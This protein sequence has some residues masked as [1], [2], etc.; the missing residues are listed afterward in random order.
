[1]SG[2]DL[3]GGSSGDYL[4][5]LEQM[6][7]LKKAFEKGNKEVSDKIDDQSIELHQLK[8]SITGDDLGN[9]GIAQR[10]SDTE[11]SA[12]KNRAEIAAMKNDLKWWGILVS[13]ISGI[14]AL[15]ITNWNKIFS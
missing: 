14:L 8:I 12:V 11:H 9:K 10:V 3:K 7:A 6:E 4:R 15:I 2:D 1:M 13:S 5:L